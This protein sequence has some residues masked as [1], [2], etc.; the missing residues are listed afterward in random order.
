MKL[1]YPLIWGCVLASVLS[2]A[3]GVALSLTTAPSATPAAGQTSA[4]R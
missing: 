1:F 3:S 4:V 2:L